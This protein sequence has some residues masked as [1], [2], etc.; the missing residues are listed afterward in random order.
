[1]ATPNLSNAHVRWSQDLL[2]MESRA[3]DVI[4]YEEQRY[5]RKKANHLA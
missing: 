5:R 4:V 1:M 2:T 3:L